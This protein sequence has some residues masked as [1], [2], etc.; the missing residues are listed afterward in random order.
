MKRFT[1]QAE[2]KTS[3]HNMGDFQV[4]AKATTHLEDDLEEMANK[5]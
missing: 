1:V 3:A 2:C 5:L 4:T